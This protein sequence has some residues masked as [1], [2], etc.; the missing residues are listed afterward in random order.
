MDIR[1]KVALITGAAK[2]VGRA[3]ALRLAAGG[4][5]VAVHYNRS[6]PDALACAELCRGH[7]VQAGTFAADLDDLQA[8]AGLVPAVEAQ[9]GRLDILVNNASVFEPMTIDEFD[10]RRWERTMRINLTSPML[11]SH[12]AQ[13]AF[14]RVGGGR[15]LNLCD[16]AAAHPQP[17]RLA[18]ITSK[19][20]LETLT[21]AL[22][23]AMAP[24]VNVV[25]IAPG[26][27]TW[28]DEY[29]RD[30]RERLTA[31]IPLKRPGTADEIAAAVHYILTEGDYMT[32][33]ILTLDGGRHL[34]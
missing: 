27:A 19:G 9:F 15:I 24:T 23:G 5:H 12:A 8:A 22:A 28:A 26:V 21:K 30:E 32:G 3:I 1:D 16:S 20:A 10:A 25:G 14:Q 2:R 29:D 34:R 4:C 33:T 31:R 7:G 17:G 11:L 13:A 18:Y 6:K